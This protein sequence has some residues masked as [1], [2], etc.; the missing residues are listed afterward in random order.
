M[1]PWAAALTTERVAYWVPPL[2]DLVQVLYLDQLEALQLTGQP[3]ELQADVA[4]RLGQ[5]LPP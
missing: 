1:P 5:S 4:L 2:H 3:K